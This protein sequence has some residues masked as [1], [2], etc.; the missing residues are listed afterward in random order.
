MQPIPALQAALFVHITFSY[1][2][3]PPALQLTS[4]VIPDKVPYLSELVSICT[5][6]ALVRSEGLLHQVCIA[7]GIGRGSIN[8]CLLNDSERMNSPGEPSGGKFACSDG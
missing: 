5:S 1:T 6:R 8:V 3:M 4:C 7:C 2:P